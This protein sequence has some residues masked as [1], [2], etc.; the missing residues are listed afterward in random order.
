MTNKA[1]DEDV[2]IPL[3]DRERELVKAY[4]AMYGLSEDEAASKLTNEAI[5]R[6]IKRRTGKTPAKTYSIKKIR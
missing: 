3:T 6:R 5:A 4:A 1:R 2:P